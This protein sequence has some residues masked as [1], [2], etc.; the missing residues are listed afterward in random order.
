VLMLTVTSTPSVPRKVEGPLGFL[1]IV[2]C[3][4]TWVFV[5]HPK[6]M[7]KRNPQCISIKKRCL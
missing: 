6:F 3:C 4:Y 2:T 7:L 5:T 1:W